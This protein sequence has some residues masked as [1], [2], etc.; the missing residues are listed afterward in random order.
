MAAALPALPALPALSAQAAGVG[1]A[2]GKPVYDPPVYRGKL[3][4]PRK[5]KSMPSVGGHSLPADAG[6]RARAR[7]KPPREP[8]SVPA[9][10]YR[11]PS[12][13]LW[14]SGSG[15]A[16]LSQTVA[17]RRGG[18]TGELTRALTGPRRAGDLPLTVTALSAD[19][20]GRADSSG[21]A[22]NAARTPAAVHVAIASRR[23][24]RADGVSGL[25]FGVSGGAGRV[26]VRLDYSRFARN[27]GG[28][29]A[30]RLR[31][32]ELP[33][34]AL[35]TPN[36]P[37]CRT[38]LRL[39]GSN[40]GTHSV[41]ATVTLGPVPAGTGP[42]RTVPARP[43]PTQTGSAEPQFS[44]QVGVGAAGSVVLATISTPAGEAGNYAAT[45]LNPEGT[46]SVNQG[47][48]SYNYPIAV[49]P[50]L[51]GA[52]PD[53]TLS[54][55]SQ[56]IDGQTS[57]QN[58][59]GS[60]IGD[61]WTY[62]PG[63]IE[64]SYESCQQDSAAT[65]AEAGDECW[66]GYNATLSL[67]GHS[68][69]L[70]GSGPGTWHLQGDDGTSIQ[71]LTGGSNGMW[72]GEYWLVTTTDGTKYYFG[73]N[74]VPGASTSSL[75]TNSAWNVPVYCP[76]ST[77]PCHSSTWTQMPYRWSL[78]YVVDPDNNLTVYNYATE[79]NFY[80]RGGATGSGTLTSYIRGGYLTSVQYG[81]HLADATASPAVNAAD[82]V[83][84]TPSARCTA[85]SCS[86]VTQTAY[87]DVPTDQICAS[88]ST[89]CLN[90]APTFFSEQRTTEIDTYV[91]ASQS[92]GTYN[93]VDSYAL[94]QQFDTGTGESSAVMALTGITRT[95]GQTGT[96]PLIPTTQFDVTMKDNRVAGTTQ[97]ALYR[98]R[99]SEI[100]TE[101]GSSI[102]VDYN[103]PQCTQGTGGNI[104]NSDAPTNTLACFP[105]YWAP[106]NQVNS[107]DWF[108]YYT[109]SQVETSDETGVGSVPHITKYFY[110]PSGVAWH[111][112]ENLAEPSKYRTW[113]EFR[114]YLSV[115]ATTG[116]APDPV[117]ETMTYYLRGMDGD[118]NGSGGTRSVSV[119]DTIGDSYPDSNFLAGKVLETA[120]YNQA[121]GSPDAETVNGPWTF[122]ST[123]SM[124]PP[125]GSGL[126]T[127]SSFMLAQSRTR[128]RRLL[129]S[130]SWETSAT[131]S[132]Y[133]GNGLIAAVDSAPAGLTETCT[134]TSYATPPAG[135]A[136]ML[137]YPD[138]IQQ[139]TG[140]YSTTTSTCPDATGRSLL[141]DKQTYYDDQ[142]AS[143]ST[144]GTAS[145]GT[146][147]HLASPG[148]LTTGTQS[149]TGW[150]GGAEVWQPE[151]AT[152]TDG[153]GRD[154]VSYDAD[155]NKS[156]TAYTPATGALPT[157]VLKKN[158]LGWSTTTA[159]NQNLQL[160]V[161]VTDQN[162]AVTTEAYDPL[163]RV[164]SV[165]LPLDQ[166][167]AATYKY[168]YS[169]TGTSPAAVTTQT[170]RDDGSYS[171]NVQI[172][173]GMLQPVE[174]Q[175]STENNAAGRLVSYT[176]Y[177]S[178]GLQATTTTRPFYDSSAG[179]SG[180][181]FIP[182]AGQIPAQTV[183][184][185][186][187]QGRT[188]A[189]AF[190]S[191][192]VAQW[193]TSTSYPGLD[194]TDTT[195]PAG[196][197]PT[198]VVTN[199]A[200]QKTQSIQDYT[201]TSNA[202]TTAYTYTPLGQIAS[203]SD[204]NGNTWSYTYDLLGHELTETDPGTTGGPGSTQPGTTSY[205]YD[206]NG[207]LTQSTDPTG[208][209]LTYKYDAQGRKTGEYNDT[210][211][212]PVLL[213]S[214]AYDKTPLNGGTADALGYPSSSTS[215]D[216]SGAAYTE[217][218]TGYNTAYEPTGTSLSVP[219]SQGALAT[220]TSSNQ[221]TTSTAYTPRTGLAEYTT[222]SADGGLPAETVQNTY[223]ESGLTTQFGDANDYLDNVSYDPLGQVLSTTFGPFG[224]QL[225]Q[226]YAYDAGTART[227]QTTT[228]LQTL[229]AA[230]D[231]TSYTYDPSGNLTSISDAQNSGGTETQCLTYNALD[232][233]TAAWTDTGGT[234]LASG[235]SAGGIG[236]CNNASPAATAIG[237]PAPYWES[238]TYDLLGDRTSETTYNTSLPASQDTPANATTQQ[239]EY[240]GGNLTNSPSS[241]APA[242]AQ[243]QP[244]SAASIVTASPSGSTT[245]T[246]A[247]NVNGQLTSQT[248]TKT[249]G[250][251]PTATPPALSKVT[252]T[253]Q[254]QVASVTTSSGTTNYSYDTNGA[255][256][257]E[258]GPSGTTL[259][260]DGGAEQITLAA[261]GTVSGLRLFTAPG[262]VTVTESS[263]GTDSYEIANQQGTATEDIQAGSLAITRRYFDPW[264]QQAG[265]RPA[266]PDSNSF[267]GKPQDPNSG[268]DVLGARDYD[269][270]T[271]SFLSLDPILETASPQQMGGY[272]YAADNPATKS[273]P[274][275]QDPI[276][277]AIYSYLASHP[278]PANNK[279]L[280]AVN[281]ISYGGGGYAG[282]SGGGLWPNVNKFAKYYQRS[283]NPPIPRPKP[284]LCLGKALC[285]MIPL[286]SPS[287]IL[288]IGKMQQCLR[289]GPKCPQYNADTK[290]DQQSA[291]DIANL[292]P[293]PSE[294]VPTEDQNCNP[295]APPNFWGQVSAAA[296]QIAQAAPDIARVGGVLALGAI[297]W[298][299]EA[300]TDFLCTGIAPYFA[301]VA[302]NL[303]DF[304]G[305]AAT[306]HGLSS[307]P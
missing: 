224:T 117:T 120:T 271:G 200:S 2:A 60:Q 81:W 186:D 87:P 59:Q 267:L 43:V 40:D 108:D 157:S 198:K 276:A 257:I 77:D 14:P 115:E 140:A 114:G 54:Y 112:D 66:D 211:G 132:Y 99:I 182:N 223:D 39:P 153:Y 137:T 289:E 288:S 121:G 150:S 232:Q 125:S 304:G 133:N 294:C 71:L 169:V 67:A 111:Y 299:C 92:S 218:V 219:S 146:L 119:S 275:G 234:S 113:D 109:V 42:A 47:S 94:T 176:T 297:D 204:N 122:N 302:S 192:G 8:G 295:I 136:M 177:N 231:T 263:S 147:G 201:S 269:P 57:A 277:S 5:L 32:V 23:V 143:I 75:T 179:P 194:Q 84:F 134:T 261:G 173:D 12:R 33:P 102:S 15:T 64:Q 53:V 21:Q 52:A 273:D 9:V 286:T 258:A 259:Y 253:P 189:S 280:A 208:T 168:S 191:L 123:A 193:Q 44:S 285:G 265:P 61:G 239:A 90:A 36:V 160:P 187:G 46:W 207:N 154:T 62:S 49:P 270:A 55:N 303:L 105:A 158:P 126:S 35:T 27:Y 264:G 272:A 73:A 183:T 240:P 116:Q 85:S 100:H 209:V 107:M 50:S 6:K 202:D 164:T 159:M 11:V 18:I 82:K 34:C 98:P 301:D 103:P 26:R 144:T 96:T 262:G 142:T 306:L 199:S 145:F 128:T 70:V 300:A 212:T 203:I 97:P 283:S 101:A 95:T 51:G 216:G 69:V 45:S 170:L 226:G 89:T 293:Q 25:V 274:S 149:A 161:T 74:H 31:L 206:G 29:W 86:S 106:P 290:A 172:Y 13:L 63:F 58:P 118:N 38:P 197:T 162:G 28:S 167:I 1:Q 91:L 282:G 48:F 217:S 233:L 291:A 80:M 225:V 278:T 250:S 41:W 238:Y 76:A 260:A 266:W 93:K 163:G 227:L 129:A 214:W 248:V 228:N 65:T 180:S 195:P 22:G 7:L 17:V 196:G 130:G 16:Q 252:Y 235:Q 139:V 281:S 237:G 243:V 181:F 296:G 244:D 152:Q 298:L 174:G 83:V 245:I 210:S 241:N 190:Y 222:Y 110:P 236:G 247:Y 138:E 30:S 251:A 127:V 185:Y 205:A 256:L 287:I 166:G 131:T 221:Y 249:S 178:E 72:N 148:G 4:S 268:L 79:S 230:A 24:A 10:P 165:T 220:G 242:T 141:S 68:G 213:D 188:T 155:G 305:D 88:G 254:G 3:W 307:Q 124:T 229:S 20:S 246:P 37:G 156:T 135:N 184:S 292:P 284:N 56:T 19:S 175:T 104:T 78:D 255:L 215:Y 171:S 151:T 279:A